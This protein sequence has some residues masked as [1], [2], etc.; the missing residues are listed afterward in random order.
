[1]Q[2]VAE[3]TALISQYGYYRFSIAALAER[4]GLT[5]AGV[6]HHVGSKEQL[7]IDILS[8]RDQSAAVPLLASAVDDAIPVRAA[9]DE[10]VRRNLQQREIVRLYAVLSAE[11]MDPAHPAHP[12]FLTRQQRSITEL[13]AIL[14]GPARA[15]E[16]A[17][18][19]VL[20]FLDGLQTLWLRDE[21]IDFWAQ[22]TA[23][24]DAVVGPVTGAP[25]A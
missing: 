21:T 3:A 16:E 17:A 8:S 22:W 12:Y 18:V 5:R 20:A 1:M 14:G 4:C 6:L 24:A 9:L 23:F 7:L 2:L 15:G 25:R 11:S 19:R 10:V 13:T